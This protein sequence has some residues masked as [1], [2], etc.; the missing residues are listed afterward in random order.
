MAQYWMTRLILIGGAGESEGE[1][2]V[3]R[4]G[5]ENAEGVKIKQTDEVESTVY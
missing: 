3:K 4:E 2:K 1:A 5:G